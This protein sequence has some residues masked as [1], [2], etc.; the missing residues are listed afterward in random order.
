MHFMLCIHETLKPHLSKC[1]KFNFVD[2]L[3]Y[4]TPF[5][6]YGPDYNPSTD[7]EDRF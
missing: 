7:I 3:F 1:D 4:H 5:K 2:S 6:S